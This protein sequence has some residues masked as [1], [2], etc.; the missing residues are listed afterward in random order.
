MIIYCHAKKENSCWFQF[1]KCK[2]LLHI[3][4]ISL[5]IKNGTQL[6]YIHRSVSICHV[7][8]CGAI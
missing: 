8:V 7:F 1:L 3:C 5:E 6:M 4:S 2:D